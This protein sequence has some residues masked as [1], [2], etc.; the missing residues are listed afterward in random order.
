MCQTEVR[1]DLEAQLP[2]SG[3]LRVL[4]DGAG[5]SV[6]RWNPM[7]RAVKLTVPP[8][9]KGDRASDWDRLAAALGAEGLPVR[10]VN[11]AVCAGLGRLLAKRRGEVWAVV[12]NGRVLDVRADPPEVYM[13]AFDL[14]TTSIAG[15]LIHVNGKDVPVA[16]GM[17]NPQAQYG[18]DVISRADWALNNGVEALSECA[19]DALDGLI[20]RMCAGAG[21]SR[22]RVYAVSLEIGRAR[23]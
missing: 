13:A 17:R 6:R 10:E 4:M 19:R 5:E 16:E 12:S 18:G 1:G 23:V 22:E 11:L 3:R 9:E 20:R 21:V 7:V 15:Y 8:C 2:E 14:G